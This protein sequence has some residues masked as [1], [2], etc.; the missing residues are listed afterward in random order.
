MARSGRFIVAVHILSLLAAEN[1]AL[2][3]ELI[4][5]SVNTNAVSIR[6]VLGLLTKA[7]LVR[8]TEGAGGGTTLARSPG[9][10]TLAEIFKAVEDQ[11]EIFGSPRS[12]PNPRCAVG[13]CVQTITKQQYI[14]T[15][16][17]SMQREM[18]RQTLADVLADVRKQKFPD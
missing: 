10:I 5:G 15:F 11:G 17:R 4:A 9:K 6:R 14:R 7:G 3:S 2:S 8:S 16:E 13:R 12:Q 1:R 18:K